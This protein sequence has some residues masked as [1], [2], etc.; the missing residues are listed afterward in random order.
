[1]T[2]IRVPYALAV[3]GNQEIQ[4][5]AKALKNP[6][7]IVA[8]DAVK[9]FEER[10][11]KIFGKKYGVMVNSGSS[12]NLLAFDLLD[13]PR[14]AEVITPLLTFGTTL[15]PI[16]KNALIPVF[17]DVGMG[18]FV[19]NVDQVESLITK[20]TRALMI[21]SLL[22]NLPDWVR[23]RAIA[24]THNLILID[25][26]CDT[27]GARFAGKPTG[28]YSDIS[29]TSFYASHIITTAGAGGMA[30]FHDKTLADR[31][32]IKNSWGR[33]STL[34]GVHESSENLSRRFAGVIDEKPYD[35]KFIFSEIGFNFQPTELQGVFGLEQLKRFPEFARR[36]KNNFERLMYFFAAYE[37]VFILPKVHPNAETNWL[38]FPL[39]IRDGAGFSRYQITKYLEEQNI[40]TR[41][42]FTGNALKQPAFQAIP[43]R[44]LKSGYP[45]TDYIMHHG[46]LIGCHHGLRDT[47]IRYLERT[48]T[49]FLEPYR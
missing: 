22:G 15:S 26:S 23:L 11:A 3:Y 4:A 36:R 34:F 14:G 42:I 25:D 44:K 2:K 28:F 18:T 19:I 24:N 1:M 16:L 33:A 30:V 10:I 9:K 29:T 43:H 37:S 48:F 12:A 49:K 45:V 38:A 32:R 20:R 5:V 47:H 8:G 7:R 13:L 31:A 39:I 35:A 21:P 6:A 46:F 41:P 40:Q 17:A 27:L